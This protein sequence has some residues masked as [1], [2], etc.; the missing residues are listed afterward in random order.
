MIPVIHTQRLIDIFKIIDS[1][2]HNKTSRQ[3]AKLVQLFFEGHL[4]QKSADI[5][6]LRLLPDLI[7]TPDHQEHIL[8]FH[9]ER[10]SLTIDPDRLPVNTHPA[11]T[12]IML[13]FPAT[14]QII[15]I[16]LQHGQIVGID[17]LSV[18]LHHMMKD[19]ARKIKTLRGTLRNIIGV[20]GNIID[21]QIIVHAGGKKFRCLPKQMKHSILIHRIDTSQRLLLLQIMYFLFCHLLILHR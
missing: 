10:T 20:I 1:K 2:P 3:T 8:I 4:T 21:I 5:I 6:R 9:P 7:D 14:D 11:I 13:I 15:Q 16:L 19:A 18:S 17:K 12:E